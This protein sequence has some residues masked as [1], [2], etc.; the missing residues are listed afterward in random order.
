LKESECKTAGIP[1]VLLFVASVADQ[2]PNMDS[3]FMT[4]A[5]PLGEAFS[6][7]VI[8]ALTSSE[9]EA[10][11]AAESLMRACIDKGKIN[12]KTARKGLE[13]VKPAQQQRS[14][15]PVIQKIIGESS[16]KSPRNEKE[17]VAS[18]GSKSTYYR[19]LYPDS[20][21]GSDDREERRKDSRFRVLI[22]TVPGVSPDCNKATSID[23]GI[24]T[25]FMG[26]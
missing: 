7:E 14:V 16:S 1:D 4:R 9:S 6:R 17:N 18:K 20:S 2:L 13:H 15:A 19:Y 22:G 10:R 21:K 5:Q 26:E 11:A 24:I 12:A 3:L 8:N 23:H 25:D